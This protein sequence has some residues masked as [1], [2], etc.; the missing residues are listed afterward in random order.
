METN[1][2]ICRIAKLSKVWTTGRIWVVVIDA[3]WLLFHEFLSSIL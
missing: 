2:L 1:E 3:H